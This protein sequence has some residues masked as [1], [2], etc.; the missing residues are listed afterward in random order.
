MVLIYLICETL[1]SMGLQKVV[2][3]KK[4]IVK[5]LVIQ[6]KMIGDVLLS[7]LI[8]KNLKLWNP[9]VQIDFVAN[10]QT[11]DVIR[12]N[13]YI[14]DLVIFEDH[15][16]KDKWGLIQFLVKRRK[17]KY[18]Y[19]I[20]AYGK[21][22]SLLICL[23]T[24]AV[25]KIGFRKIYSSWVYN[26]LVDKIK[27]REGE[28]QSSIKNRFQLLEPIMGDF[29]KNSDVEIQLTSEEILASRKKFDQ[30]LGKGNQAIMVSALGSN[31]NKTYPLNYL[32]QLLD[33]TFEI[34]KLPLILN[35]RPDQET[36]IDELIVQ[37]KPSTQRAV[38]KSLT[39]KSLRD[40]MA[41]VYHCVAAVG[42]EGGALNIA[43][44][45]DKPTFAIFSPLI[46]PSGWHTEIHNRSM[47]VDVRSFF[48]NAIVYSDHRKTGKD[49]KKVTELYK[50]LKPE[51]FK[52]KWIDFLKNCTNSF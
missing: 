14:D 50:M 22:E 21:I 27:Y 31:N 15:F 38:I 39:P 48:P 19:I 26:E 2:S 35:Y 5:V 10:R 7:S 4:S 51:L 6:Q 3:K 34:T 40:Y 41:S 25:K 33:L 13:P 11:L 20:D 18:D 45:L 43:K 47:A 12:N 29:P 44:G 36:K 37:L 16:K 9:N 17:K 30:E 52:R 8:C 1:N 42:N 24:P 28:L 23:L 46:D 49:P 32:S